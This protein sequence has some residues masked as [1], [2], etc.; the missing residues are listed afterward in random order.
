MGVPSLWP[1]MRNVVGGEGRDTGKESVER[2]VMEE[3]R[4]E[5]EEERREG[6]RWRGGGE[7]SSFEMP[8]GMPGMMVS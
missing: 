1:R 3:A 6:L 5:V 8:G 2:D 7:A 4:R